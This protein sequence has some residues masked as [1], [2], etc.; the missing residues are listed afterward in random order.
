MVAINGAIRGA[1]FC[2][3]T[4]ISETDCLRHSFERKDNEK[5]PVIMLFRGDMKIPIVQY[6]MRI[7][8]KSWLNN[9][10]LGRPARDKSDFSE[11]SWNIS[12]TTLVYEPTLWH[13]NQDSPEDD[14]ESGG[15]L[16]ENLE[17]EEGEQLQLTSPFSIDPIRGQKQE[18]QAMQGTKDACKKMPLLLMQKNGTKSR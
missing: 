4:S 2:F 17:A 15:V 11:T 10:K 12:I 1:M 16:K 3:I 13:P 9:L 8:Q 18:D 5:L 6:G 7:S 14:V